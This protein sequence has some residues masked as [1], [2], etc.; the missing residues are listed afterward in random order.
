MSECSGM[1]TILG[2]ERHRIPSR[3]NAAGSVCRCWLYAEAESV[4]EKSLLEG[5]SAARQIVNC[6]LASSSSGMATEKSEPSV[7]PSL[8]PE[9]ALVELSQQAWMIYSVLGQIR[10]HATTLSCESPALL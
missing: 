3:G 7:G 4:H 6:G 1:P 5:G 2:Q 9:S 10:S 8:R